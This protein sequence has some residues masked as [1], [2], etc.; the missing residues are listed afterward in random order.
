MWPQN[1]CQL[2]LLSHVLDTSHANTTVQ[3]DSLLKTPSALNTTCNNNDE[4]SSAA[5]IINIILPYMEEQDM[6]DKDELGEY[7]TYM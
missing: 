1:L 3:F 2:C 5:G 6:S 7:K 4:A